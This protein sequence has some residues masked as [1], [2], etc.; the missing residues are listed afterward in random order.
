MLLNARRSYVRY[1]LVCALLLI[2]Y[3]VLLPWDGQALSTV[4]KTTSSLVD[5][6]RKPS[7]GGNDVPRPKEAGHNTVDQKA[8]ED[9]GKA[10]EEPVSAKEHYKKL[11]EIFGKHSPDIQPLKNYKDDTKAPKKAFDDK[12]PV[13]TNEE[14]SEFLQ[15]SDE[16]KE[17]LKRA[18]Q[19]IVKDLPSEPP[20]GL[21]EGTGV[22]TT[23]GARYMPVMLNTLRMLRRVS[24][25]VPVEVFVADKEE[26]EPGIC[27]EVLPELNAKCVVLEDIYGADTFKDFDIHG[28]QFKVL[29]ILASRFEDVIF[30]DSDSV[31]IRD[32][33][34][35]TLRE[36][37]LSTGY[38]LWPDYWFRTTSPAYYDIIGTKLG[39]RVRGDLSEKDP[40]KIPQADREGAI[41]DK[42][43]ESGQ[44]VISKKRHY[45]SLLLATHFNL[46]GYKA[47]YQ[48]FTQ[49]SGGEGDK[50][51]YYAAA[52]ALGEDVHHV[53]QDCRP[54]GRFA[55][56]FIGAGMLQVDPHDDY[57]KNVLKTTTENPR[58]MFMHLNYP[59][60]NPKELFVND[61]QHFD[62]EHEENRVRYYGKPSENHHLFDDK[63]IELELWLEAQWAACDIG[64][65]KGIVFND[66]KDLDMNDM[67]QRIYDHVNWLK[68]THNT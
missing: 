65:Y 38:I 58:V 64:V 17:K 14:L 37:Y 68:S 49:G 50:E 40:K 9:T 62:K 59:K 21:Y 6:D 7:T 55:P 16:D 22:V 52:L 20:K 5:F 4:T 66:W 51:T 47:Y 19:G 11:F 28:Y 63:D 33:E 8:G 56:D 13:F 45:K 27:E 3:V 31:P 46:E 53:I 39:E 43:T 12:L 1:F 44:I 32:I 54:T 18:Y 60:L 35:L 2:V 61:K 15:V 25:H 30:I 29:A 26:Y 24:P 67:C 34:T 36:P 23:S 41:P 57:Q 42:S 10:H 48:L